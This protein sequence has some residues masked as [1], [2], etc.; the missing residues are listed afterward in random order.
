MIRHGARHVVLLGRGKPSPDVMADVEAMTGDDVNVQIVSC[1]VTDEAALV[2]TLRDL[3]RNGRP[4]RGVIH[5]AMVLDDQFVTQLDH[6]QLRRVL[7]PK[8]AGAW[9]LDATTR[10]DPLDFFVLFSSFASIVG[11]VGQANYAAANAFLDALAHRRRAEGR[12]ALAVNWGAIAA[13]GYVARHANIE[14]HFQR[15]GLSALP[16]DEAFAVLDSL[17]RHETTQ[18]GIVDIDWAIWGR[19]APTIARSPTF[20]PLLQRQPAKDADGAESIRHRLR[21]APATERRG[22]LVG[23]MQQQ[24]AAVLGLD[25]AQIDAN[26]ELSALGLDSLMA[27]ELS[28]LIEDKLGFKLGTIELIQAPSL[29]VLADRLVDKVELS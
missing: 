20:A 19:Y 1:D 8:I 26:Q 7:A 24:L 10:D 3:R 21:A 27:I 16:P 12:P 29:T 6:R 15:Q 28:C 22:I 25:A 2:A 11:N 9:A 13:S 14:Q 4:L 18:V 17:L 23:A 5:C